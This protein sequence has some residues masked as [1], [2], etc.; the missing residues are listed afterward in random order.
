MKLRSDLIF[1]SDRFL[2]YFNKFEARGNNYNLFKHKILTDVLFTRFNIKT[3]KFENR[4]IIPFH[5][6]DWWLFGLKEDLDTYFMDTELVKEPEFTRYFNLEGN[7]EKFHLMAKQDLNLH[8]N[9][10][11]DI[12]ALQEILMIFIWKMPQIIQKN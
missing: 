1:T 12:P 6:S 5:V 7:Q 8:R 11:L 3:G 4:V 9:N 2:E 10:I